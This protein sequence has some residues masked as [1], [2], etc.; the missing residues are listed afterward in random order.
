VAIDNSEISFDKPII[1][2]DATLTLQSRNYFLAL[3]STIQA[4]RAELE[5]QTL[6]VGTGSPEGVVDAL[7][8]KRYMDDAGVANTI[9]YIKRDADI[10]GDT[11]KGWILT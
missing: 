2:V 10:A 1:E 7:P 5:F 3:D 6:I 11:T 9:W 4:L 8:T